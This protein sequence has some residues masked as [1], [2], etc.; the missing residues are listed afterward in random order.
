[1]GGMPLF[2]QV[3]LPLGLDLLVTYYIMRALFG[4]VWGWVVGVPVFLGL[5]LPAIVVVGFLAGLVG[6]EPYE[7]M[8]AF[9]IGWEPA[10][11][12]KRRSGRWHHTELDQRMSA[13]LR[14]GFTAAALEHFVKED[15]PEGLRAGGFIQADESLEEMAEATFERTTGMVAVTDKRLLFLAEGETSVDLQLSDVLS[16]GFVG[17]AASG[18]VTVTTPEGNLVFED[19][20]PR[21]AAA[22]IANALQAREP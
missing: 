22:R 10:M 9:E 20:V 6:F 8:R 11:R 13:E 19:I 2:G 7:M 1:V 3:I 15:A 18:A 14:E 12:L 17:D 21:L 16:V 5:A 4:N